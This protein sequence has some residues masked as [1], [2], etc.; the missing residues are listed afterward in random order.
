MKL[1]KTKE[2]EVYYYYLKNG[3]KRFMFRHKYVNNLGKR[4]EKKKSGFKTQKDALRSLLEVKAAILSGNNNHIEHSQMTV[5][6]LLDIWVET[7]KRNWKPSTN[8]NYTNAKKHIKRLIGKYK[9]N[10]LNAATYEREFVNQ[11]FSEGFKPKSILGFHEVFKTAVNF[12]VHD[13]IIFRNR[14]SNITITLDEEVNN[15]FTPEE[16]KIFLTTAKTFGNIT[17]YTLTLLLAYSGMR[18]GES[19][20]LKWS[21]VDFDNNIVTI[22]R[23]RDD[24]GVRPPKT[25]NS[26]R[27]IQVD[28]EVVDQLNKYEKWCIETKFSLGLKHTKDDFLFISENRVN[29]IQAA[30]MNYFLNILYKKMSEQNIKLKK[31]TVHGLRHTHATILID[32]LIPPTDIADRLGNTLEMI[33]RVYAHSFKKVENKTV[34][35]FG[36]RL[37][38]NIK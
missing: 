10:T 12:A 21:D 3:D 5:S 6:Q 18:K 33:Y 37:K 26:Y 23:T 29:G 7:K 30:Y 34:I 16:L 20:G 4:R 2:N 13:E 9:I 19:L 28:K 11:L 15:F 17:Q 27:S 38:L 25:K 22:K 35:A 14:F 1:Q 24:L 32:E 36:N 31:I 8:R